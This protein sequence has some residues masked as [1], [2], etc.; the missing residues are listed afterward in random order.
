MGICPAYVI[1]LCNCPIHPAHYYYIEIGQTV[2]SSCPD[3]SWGQKKMQTILHFWVSSIECGVGEFFLCEWEHPT[4]L[5]TFKSS[6]KPQ[7]KIFTGP[8]QIHHQLWASTLTPRF[9]N[10]INTKNMGL[11]H[12]TCSDDFPSHYKHNVR[13]RNDKSCS[14]LWSVYV[15]RFPLTLK[16]FSKGPN[17]KTRR[18]S[19]SARG[20]A[21]TEFPHG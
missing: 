7:L 11:W 19:R 8:W 2:A 13:L 5:R 6:G 10:D 12:C 1:L 18:V 17:P 15:S 3:V 20:L 14:G 9:K 4:L 21:S 16:R